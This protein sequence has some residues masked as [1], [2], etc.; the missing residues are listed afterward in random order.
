MTMTLTLTRMTVTTLTTAEPES[1]PSWRR[2]LGN[3]RVRVVVGYVALLA[4]ALAISAV[5]TRQV[6][7]ARLDGEIDRALA[8]EVEE[9]RLLAGGTDPNTG[10]PF[11]TDAR[12]I[13]D[14]FLSRSVPAD[15]EAFYTLLQGE[16]YLRDSEAPSE[17]FADSELVAVW[18]AATQPRR[19]SAQ[20]EIGEVQYLAAP[21]TAG[22]T[23]QAT[24][25][26]LH[27]PEP[28]RDE[29]LQVL[30]V[31]LVTG[32]VVL[33]ASA[34]LAWSLAGRV[35][36]PVRDLTTTAR[37]VT[38]TDLSARIPVVGDDELAELGQT[39]NEMLDRLERGF[40]TQ[41]SFLDDVAHELRTPITIAQGH[42]EFLGDD[43]AEREETVAIVND[44]LERMSRYVSDLILLA[45][46]EQP[47]FLRL[48]PIDLGEF[49]ESLMPRMVGLGERSWVL[50]EAPPPGR[51][52][53]VADP[54]RL[55]QALLNLASNAVQH[56][57]PGEEIGL[58][59][60]LHPGATGSARPAARMWV[61][62]TGPGIDPTVRASL[63]QR[64]ARGVTS[65]EGRPEGMGI[66][67]SIVDA[68]ARGHG[69][70]VDV[71]SEAGAGSRF[72]ITVPI[73]PDSGFDDDTSVPQKED[74]T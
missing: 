55:S 53:I 52:A 61:R 28:D 12:A 31:V 25:V 16:P 2:R 49:A 9:L 22:G 38:D 57:G 17:L 29:V 73:G 54:G 33:I 24:F 67:L 51:L 68:I 5:V 32:A 45:K 71:E 23:S 44:E 10:E 43:P 1:S 3:I 19:G 15:N 47:D 36:R 37:E 62:D 27:F 50:D 56:T 63:F 40:E 72:V 70:S 8:Q 39:F 34:A 64:H 7:L 35:L 60:D 4:A 41:R 18:A 74:H 65:R 13:V 42:L 21:L 14:T 48:Q 11:G 66:G 20:T 26:V 59:I 30:R 69:G 46:A 6:L 58:G